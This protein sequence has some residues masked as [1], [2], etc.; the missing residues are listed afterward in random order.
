MEK[1]KW[2]Y[3]RT[4]TD[5][6]HP[7][8]QIRDIEKTYEISEKD[9]VLFS[10]KESAWNEVKDREDFDRLK[11]IIKRAKGGDLYVW[12]WDRIWRNRKRLKEFFQ[13][14]KLYKVKIHSFRQLFYESFHDIPSPFDEIMQELFLNLLGWMSEDESKKKSDRVMAARRKV[15]PACQKINNADELSCEKCKG[16]LKNVRTKSYKG[17]EWGRKNLSKQTIRKILQLRT[18][19]PKISIREIASQVV[20]YDKNNNAKN[21]SR[22]AV[23]KILNENQENSSVNELVKEGVSKSTN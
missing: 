20:Y 3:I 17:N 6:Q 1:N 5:D 22:S 16:S 10:D 12:D 21:V 13:L 15:C 8:N 18:D 23:H 19:N 7:E 4:S 14:C 11:S 9:Y 2:V